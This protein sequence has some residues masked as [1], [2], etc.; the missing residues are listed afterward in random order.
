MARVVPVGPIDPELYAFAKKEAEKAE[1]N[2]RY[3]PKNCP[4]DRGQI[5][6]KRIGNAVKAIIRTIGEWGQVNFASSETA[7]FAANRKLL[8]TGKFYE[9][10]NSPAIYDPD[11][12][13]GLLNSAIATVELSGYSTD[14]HLDWFDHQFIYS[15]NNDACRRESYPF[16]G[17]S[18]HAAYCLVDSRGT[19][20]WQQ[21]TYYANANRHSIYGEIAL[22]LD[23]HDTE[24]YRQDVIDEEVVPELLRT[25][26]LFTGRIFFGSSTM[27]SHTLS[28]VYTKH[29]SSD[30]MPGVVDGKCYCTY[31]ETHYATVD[32]A[33]QDLPVQWMHQR[34]T[35]VRHILAI[36]GVEQEI[37][38]ITKVEAVQ[39]SGLQPLPQPLPPHTFIEIRNDKTGKTG[40]SIYMV[41]RCD[42]GGVYLF[43][44]EDC[45]NSTGAYCTLGNEY[46]VFSVTEKTTEL[47]LSWCNSQ[48]ME[49]IDEDVHWLD[50]APIV[51][52]FP[53]FELETEPK[54]TARYGIKTGHLSR[55]VLFDKFARK[56]LDITAMVKNRHASLI[57]DAEFISQVQKAKWRP[58]DP[59]RPVSI[60]TGL[61]DD[62]S[63]AG[64]EYVV[65]PKKSNDKKITKY[66]RDNFETDE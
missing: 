50:D 9:K 20:P 34:I 63:I 29:H 27:N 35:V 24:F 8:T 7:F 46:G 28:V 26:R 11:A 43:S 65:N 56:S 48:N 22:R 62:E 58:F 12:A 32:V 25:T 49:N 57:E 37:G 31:S 14:E 64:F 10:R 38:R 18:D 17:L 53:K 1:R 2:P 40:E 60:R 19:N 45:I 52:N 44:N 54:N 16:L 13:L 4:A 41:A 23:N 5:I 3:V 61:I 33:H 21:Y 66:I 47:Q 15:D 55:V 6:Y 36:D 51:C 42:G 30:P 59:G 39:G